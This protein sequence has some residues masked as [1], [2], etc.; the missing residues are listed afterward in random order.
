MNIRILNSEIFRTQRFSLSSNHTKVPTNFSMMKFAEQNFQLPIF[1]W[2]LYGCRTLK[3]KI[4][5]QPVLF[6][7]PKAQITK[8]KGH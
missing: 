2:N 3:I 7:H 5:S 8:Q 4:L 6:L 1:S